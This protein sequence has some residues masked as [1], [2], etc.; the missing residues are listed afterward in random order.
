[1]NFRKLEELKSEFQIEELTK[2]DK[3]LALT[4]NSFQRC[5]LG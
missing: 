1:M 2:I 3:Y 5:M 4:P